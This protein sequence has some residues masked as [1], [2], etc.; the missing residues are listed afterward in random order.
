MKKSFTLIL[1]FLAL[2]LMFSPNSYSKGNLVGFVKNYQDNRPVQ[3]AKIIIHSIYD[4]LVPGTE[5]TTGVD[6]KFSCKIPTSK[7]SRFLIEV[8]KEDFFHYRKDTTILESRNSSEG[9]ILLHPK[10]AVLNDSLQELW[11]NIF[12]YKTKIKKL[13]T[14]LS[15]KERQLKA[16]RWDNTRLNKE[17]RFLNSELTDVRKLVS[18]L[19]QKINL[20]KLNLAVQESAYEELILRSER[21]LDSLKDKIHTLKEELNT[22]NIKAIGCRCEEFSEEKNSITIGFYVSDKY[23][24]PVRSGKGTFML[25]VNYQ[26]LKRNWGQFQS[27]KDL[28]SSNEFVE[29]EIDFDGNWNTITF[30]AKNDVFSKRSSRYSYEVELYLKENSPDFPIVRPFKLYSLSRQCISNT[31]KDRDVEALILGRRV[32]INRDSINI[33]LINNDDSP[34]KFMITLNDTTE[35]RLQ[36]DGRVQIP[37]KLGRSDWIKLDDKDNILKIF[38]EAVGNRNSNKQSC[39]ILINDGLLKREIEFNP[40]ELLATEESNQM[41][42]LSVNL[43]YSHRY[44]SR[45]KILIQ[46][47]NKP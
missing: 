24:N 17:I 22:S 16:E 14:E 38:P 37:L 28:Y 34:K 8:D 26:N 31:D 3:G 30:T 47:L 41:K 7:N 11:K 44:I 43:I 36:L 33:I 29:K 2:L 6:G 23:F 13:E 5:A 25:K 19:S 21:E 15:S 1:G 20:L 46:R 9:V 40:T 10:S 12:V 42:V 35:W 32:E 18:G 45:E 27:I 4:T 39:S